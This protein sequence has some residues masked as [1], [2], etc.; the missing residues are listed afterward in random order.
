MLTITKAERLFH[1]LQYLDNQETATAGELAS[2]C[3]V[4]KRSIYRDM[5]L[6][7]SLGLYYISEGKQGYKLI[8]KP[9]RTPDKLNFEEWIALILFPLISKD[10][11]SGEHP[12]Y[13]AYQ[14]GL[15]KI[16][17]RV[18]DT[19]GVTAIRSHLGERILFQ[20]R[21]NDVYH[22]E[23]M[24]AV[25]EGITF[26]RRLEVNYYSMYRD[27]STHRIIHP[28]YLVPRGGHLYVI[29]FC[30]FR[31]DV[32]IFRLNRMK[33]IKVREEI[34]HIPGTFSISEFLSNRWKITAD[35]EEVTMFSV[36]FQ[37]EIAR[38]IYEYEFYTE[39][40]LDN[41]E[42]GSLLLTAKVRSREEFIRWLRSFGPLAEVLKPHEV[43]NQLYKEYKVLYN[44]YKDD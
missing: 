1:I 6:L 29:A 11:I 35:D 27:K 10:I 24:A 13:R 2:H 12:Y 22:P 15:E 32:R 41:Q 33:D 20:D 8:H 38:Y 43:R 18:A 21:Y 17:A 37:K 7:E 28:Y 4:S 16:G 44:Q 14:S 39:T 42:D 25:I 26:D 3:Q 40:Y 19:K 36:K 30:Q 9:V 23:V 34:F 31:Q 5:K